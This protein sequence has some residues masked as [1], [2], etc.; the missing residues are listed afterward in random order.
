[1]DGRTNG[2]TNGR[3]IGSLYRTIPEAG[4]TM[5]IKFIETHSTTLKTPR[6]KCDV[7]ECFENDSPKM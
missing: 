2:R 1:M 4:T 3:K 6:P 7:I 5:K